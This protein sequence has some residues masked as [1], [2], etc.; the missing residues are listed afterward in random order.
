MTPEA[1]EMVTAPAPYRT[2]SIS[3][4]AGRDAVVLEGMVMVQVPED[5]VH[6]TSFPA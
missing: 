1:G 3:V 5:L 2:I 4:S 6:F